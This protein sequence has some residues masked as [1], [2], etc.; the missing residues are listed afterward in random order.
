MAA[1]ATNETKIDPKIVRK[2]GSTSAPIRADPT[3]A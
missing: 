2:R 3:Y 1:T